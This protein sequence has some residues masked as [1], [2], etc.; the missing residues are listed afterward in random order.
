MRNV[1][2]L[3]HMLFPTDKW[4]YLKLKNDEE[5]FSY[6][7]LSVDQQVILCLFVIPKKEEFL[8]RCILYRSP[9][10]YLL[11]RF[12]DVL[13]SVHSFVYEQVLLLMY[14]HWRNLAHNLSLADVLVVPYLL[15]FEIRLFWM[16]DKFV[17]IYM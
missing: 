4:V 16:W 1:G 14:R 17:L 5:I 9:L 6:F 11:K 13:L 2:I 3:C 12:L 10:N 15:N 7:Y 8:A